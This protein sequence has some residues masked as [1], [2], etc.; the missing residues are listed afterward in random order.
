MNSWFSRLTLISY[1][2]D[3]F[4]NYIFICI[5]NWLLIKINSNSNEENMF[6]LSWVDLNYLNKSN[7]LNYVL[8]NTVLLINIF[9]K[10]F[11]FIKA[12]YFYKG[13]TVPFPKPLD[14]FVHLAMWSQSVITQIGW[15]TGTLLSQLLWEEVGLLINCWFFINLAVFHNYFHIFNSFPLHFLIL[16]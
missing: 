4:C 5:L 7:S 9:I 14:W 12:F 3:K 8:N 1:F 2:E 15:S 16:V 6:Y 13:F 11:Y 10:D